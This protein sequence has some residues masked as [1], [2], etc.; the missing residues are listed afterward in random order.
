MSEALKQLFSGS[1]DGTV[2]IWSWEEEFKCV[3]TVQ[4]QAPVEALLVFDD[5]LF[6]GCQPANGRQGVVRVWHM[7]SVFEQTL[8]GHQGAIYSL[9]CGG[10][11]P[12]G[13]PFIFSGG[14]DTGVKTWQ[15]HDS[16]HFEPVIN[17]AA[18]SAPV[19][20]MKVAGSSLVS[21][22]RNGSICMWD[23]SSG[24]LFGT[25]NTDHK[26]LTAIWL[27]E[28]YLFSAA[29]DG[30][31]KVWD[32][33][34][35]LL[36]DHVVTNR[37][38][39]PSGITAIAVVS[40]PKPA[41]TEETEELQYVLITACEDKALKLWRLPNFDKRGILAS[42]EGHADMPRCLCKGPGNSFFSGSKDRAILVW[43]FI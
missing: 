29:M 41:G 10:T 30:H 13:A 17:L 40:E 31:V 9:A 5:W 42:R 20:S 8:E 21:A 35:A 43:E 33:N 2:C 12:S 28:S 25:I 39:R 7:T 11:S 37:D 3:H 4:A 36:Q 15:F 38:N 34:G 27:E 14:D 32:A 23:L 6:A 22:D 19:V 26:D 1:R 24:Q 18:H 16:G